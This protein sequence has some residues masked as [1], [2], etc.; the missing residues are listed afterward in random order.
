MFS[1][2]IHVANLAKLCRICANLIRGKEFKKFNYAENLKKVFFIDV[3]NDKVEIHPL[4][5]CMKCYLLMNTSINRKSTISVEVYSWSIHDDQDCSVCSRVLTLK[6]GAIG[7]KSK[8]VVPNFKGRN[9]LQNVWSQ[10]ELND[11]TIEVPADFLPG[12]LKKEALNEARNPH[13]TICICP[14]CSDIMRR[15]VKMKPCEDAFCCS[16]ITKVLRGQNKT[17]KFPKSEIIVTT[18]T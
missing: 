15:P 18:F 2:D 12:D 13:L 14:I 1:N 8:K 11:L 5:F 4:K 10:G 7:K 16:C 3:I 17:T 6:R 9:S